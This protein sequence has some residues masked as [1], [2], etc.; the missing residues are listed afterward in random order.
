[1]TDQ[2]IVTTPNIVKRKVKQEEPTTQWLTFRLDN[3]LFAIKVLHILEVLPSVDVTPVPGSSCHILGIS[4][5]R[6]SM[7]T[8]VNTKSVL[9]LDKSVLNQEKK[10]IV[11]EID[12]ET[13]I[14][15]IV[16]NI[17]EII[18]VVDSTIESAPRSVDER[19]L[20]CYHGVVYTEDTELVILVNILALNFTE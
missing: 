20:G 7:L 8:L 11:V 18:N 17:D 13:V 15:F 12:E 19:Q 10:V 6:G 16:D 1:M 3:A 9:G 2:L 4:N 14:G 5:L